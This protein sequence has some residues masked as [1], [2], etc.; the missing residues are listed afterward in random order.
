MRRRHTVITAGIVLGAFALLRAPLGIDTARAASP[1]KQGCKPAS[2]FCKNVAATAFADAK[3][4]F[5]A[6]KVT[7][8]QLST[9]DDQKACLKAA[10][11]AKKAATKTKKDQ[12]KACK[13]GDKCRQTECKALPKESQGMCRPLDASPIGA[14]VSSPRDSFLGCI[15]GFLL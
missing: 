9:K 1:C 11:D 8:K 5:A 3:A 15:E 13:A 14:I 12:F 2:N 10:K 4:A 6:A 7:C